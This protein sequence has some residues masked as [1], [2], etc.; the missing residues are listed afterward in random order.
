MYLGDLISNDGSHAKN[1]QHRKNKAIGIINQ[2]MQ[3][4]ETVYFGKYY[5]EVAMIL[6]SSMLLS[7]LLLNAEAW[8]NLKEKDIRSLE[9]SDEIL[10]SK[11][12]DCEANT[13]N[14]AKYFELG[15]QPLRFEIMKKKILYLQYILKQEKSSMVFKVFEATCENMIKD[16]F[17]Q[18][19]IKYLEILDIQLSFKEIEE[20]SVWKFKKLVKEKTKLAAFRYL[21][22]K[23]NEPNKQ[24]KISHINYENLE[25]Q[26]YLRDGNRNIK[27]SQVIFKARTKT[28]DIKT[29]KKWKYDDD[30]CVGCGENQETI[31]EIL[32]CKS[33]SDTDGPDRLEYSCLFGQS[34]SDILNFG[35]VLLKRIKTREKML[36]EVT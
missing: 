18:T 14:I 8:V 13:S 31:D 32:N 23:K 34:Q 22:E 20:M 25:I 16:D 28:L 3:I 4:L 35:A 9:Q 17:V 7:S 5:F 26:E 24:L 29:W 11:V 19:C 27:I 30:L 12:L 36:E 6:R 33:L 21:L 15:V 2:I 1:V 10:L